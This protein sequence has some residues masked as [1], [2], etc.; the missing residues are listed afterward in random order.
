MWRLLSA[1]LLLGGA[2]ASGV[3]LLHGTAQAPAA[4]DPRVPAALRQAEAPSRSV[5]RPLVGRVIVLDAGHQLGNRS[6]V[7]QINAPVAAGGFEKECNTTGTATNDGY[8]EASFTFDVT[9]RAAAELRRLGARVVLTRQHNSEDLWGPCVDVRGRAGNDLGADLK[10]SIHADGSWVGHGFHVIRP[11]L[12]PGWTDDVYDESGELAR[13]LRDAL[14]ASGHATSTYRGT[15]GVDERGDLATLNLSDVPVAM[16]EAGNMRDPDEAA[17]MRTRHG[18]QGY[19]DAVVA[20]VVAFL[21][22]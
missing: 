1:L 20:G 6:H 8:A 10:V 12:L 7:A 15:R 22:D 17:L 18:R 19:A 16:V 2:V 21:S 14:V 13:R 9:R 11:A 3:L 4:P 5:A